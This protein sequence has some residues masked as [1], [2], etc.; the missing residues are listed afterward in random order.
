V[1]P[2]CLDFPVF[3]STIY[4]HKTNRFSLVLM[5]IFPRTAGDLVYPV[6]TRMGVP[7]L[8]ERWD[9]FVIAVS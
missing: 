5:Y 4:E 2:V 8:P 7:M 9:F 6:P 3:V 1:L